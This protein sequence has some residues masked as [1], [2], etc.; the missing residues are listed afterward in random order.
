MDSAVA[1][2]ANVA[3]GSLNGGG[4]AKRYGNAHASIVPYEAFQ[5][6]DAP[7][8]L[9]C[10]NNRQFRDLCAS[11]LGMPELSA[12]PRFAFEAIVSNITNLVLSPLAA[13]QI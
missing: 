1:A 5:A 10:A 7:F 8:V 2:L 3:S 6:A 4:A 12:D 9:A 11:T 13:S